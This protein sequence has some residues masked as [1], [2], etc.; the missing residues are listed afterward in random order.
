MAG[1]SAAASDDERGPSGTEDPLTGL[2]QHGA[3]QEE[4]TR[5]FATTS[6]YRTP[7]AVLLVD[8][9]EFGYVNDTLGHA[10]GDKLLI[11]VGRLVK[12]TIGSPTAGSASVGTSSPWCCRTPADGAADLGQRLLSRL[13]DSRELGDYR[14]PI[15]FSGGVAV[16]PEHAVDR[17]DLLARADAA[18]H[19]SKRAGRTLIAT[20]DSTVDRPSARR[21]RDRLGAVDEAR[22]AHRRP[23]ARRGLSADD[24]PRG[25][26]RDDRIRGAGPTGNRSGFQ[27][28]IGLFTAAEIAQA[29]H[30]CRPGV[31]RH[32]HRRCPRGAGH[33]DRP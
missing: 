32:R 19:R 10:A 14:R 23:G 4:L 6:R 3:F 29:G 12:A 27:S 1:G 30:R 25:R 9:D 13:L 24:R 8:L 21:P 16:S 20:F 33:L 15:S 2:E 26:H 5:Q 18:L 7:F 31:P 22:P 28:T 11:E 17:T